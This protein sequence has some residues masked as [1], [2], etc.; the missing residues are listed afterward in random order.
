[1]I[2]LAQR[3]QEEKAQVWIEDKSQNGYDIDITELTNKKDIKIIK[4][5]EKE[6]ALKDGSL[7]M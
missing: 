6:Y 3:I 2:G 4:D 7:S 1:M 5:E